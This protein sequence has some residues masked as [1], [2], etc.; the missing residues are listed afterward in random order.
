MA[1]YVSGLITL[2]SLSTST[3]VTVMIVVIAIVIAALV[4]G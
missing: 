1:A 2:D 3:R 4:Y